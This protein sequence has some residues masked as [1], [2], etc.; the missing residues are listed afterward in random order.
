MHMPA[1]PA[2]T[3][4]LQAVCTCPNELCPM[5]QLL[6]LCRWQL[7]PH[8]WIAACVPIIFLI[9]E[10]IAC[11]HSLSVACCALCVVY[12][13]V[14]A[15]LHGLLPASSAGSGS[16]TGMLVSHGP[17][18]AA[19]AAARNN[20]GLRSGQGVSGGGLAAAVLGSVVTA[21]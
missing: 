21:A 20:G 4:Q 15:R 12:M 5:Q 9:V 1:L 18:A 10:Q 7:L 6:Q 19:A 2:F 17:L 13:Q 11:H 8:P 16:L 3:Q 14:A